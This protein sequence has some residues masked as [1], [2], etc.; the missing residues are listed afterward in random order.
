MPRR[1][2]NIAVLISGAGTTL[3]NFIDLS[4]TGA[5][6]IDIRLVISSRPGV[7]GLERAAEAGVPAEVIQRRSHSE[8]L[9]S[10]RI[11]QA[12][13]RAGADLVCMAGFLQ[14]WIIPPEF[15]NRVMNI[16][17]ALLPSFG[18]KGYYGLRVH[19]AVLDAGC[20]VSGASV[21][22]ADNIYDHGPIILQKTAPVRENDTAPALA[23]RVR[24][25]ER[26]IYPEAVRLFAADRLRVDGRRVHILPET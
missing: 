3:Q 26:L 1:N 18:G 25:A 4:R 17:P 6:P 20:K 15:D 7:R 22:F 12:V 21:H 19:Q 10:R 11:T 14:M 13:T 16:H 23:R 8:D 24:R 9:F 5:L 2:L